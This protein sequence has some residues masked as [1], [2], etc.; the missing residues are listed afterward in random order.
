MSVI[1]LHGHEN[2][3]K[4]RQLRKSFTDQFENHFKKLAI[5]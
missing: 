5:N 2:E 4:T 1:E 3:S